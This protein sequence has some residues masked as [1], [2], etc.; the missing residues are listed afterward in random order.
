MSQEN[1][2][3]TIRKQA[4]A[5]DFSP[6]TLEQAIELAKIMADSDLV[7]S[8]MKK[9]PGNVLVAIQMGAEIGLKPMQAIQ[10]IAVINGRPTVWG[11]AALGVVQASGLL[12]NIKELDEAEALK[13]GYGRIELKRKGNKDPIVATFTKED[14]EKAGLWKKTGPWSNYPGRMLKLRARAFGLR[15]GFADVLKGLAIREEVEDYE[16]RDVTPHEEKPAIQMPRRKEEPKPLDAE[17]VDGSLQTSKEFKD[18]NL[19]D[20]G[21]LPVKANGTKLALKITFP[22]G[23]VIYA[24]DDNAQMIQDGRQSGAKATLQTELINGVDQVVNVIP[25]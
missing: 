24:K 19:L 12:E 11:D 20:L 8:D 13:L 7:P 22:E 15:N 5:V 25:S 6:K 10:N 23:A 16:I 3:L 17:V 4:F 21:I 18:V 14:A 9:K 2:S 1:G